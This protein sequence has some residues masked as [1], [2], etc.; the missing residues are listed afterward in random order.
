LEQLAGPRQKLVSEPV[1]VD[2]AVLSP[3][4][5]LIA[6]TFIGLAAISSLFLLLAKFAPKDSPDAAAVAL[7]AVMP[8]P[9]LLAP[10][11]N[12]ALSA[13]VP[14][15]VAPPER[16]REAGPWRIG[17]AESGQRLIRGTVGSNPFLKAIEVAGL[18]KNQAY[19]VYGALKEHKDLD[20]C[21]PKDQFLA[22]VNRADK[23]LV[24]FEY[25]VSK[26]EV[27]QARE[28]DGKLVGKRLDLKV[29]K[30]RVQGSILMTSAGFA[31]AAQNAGLEPSIGEVVNRAL[32]GHTGVSQFR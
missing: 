32:A 10:D 7:T 16:K 31:A 21:R 14:R 30:H 25:I 29:N 2:K 13:V 1:R 6:I 27:Y 17:A 4:T 15:P 23:R 12:A 11:P 22:L 20:R 28:V 3:T 26:E 18:E 8:R 5:T 24:A 19:R 9:T